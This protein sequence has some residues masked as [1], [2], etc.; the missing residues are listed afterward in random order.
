MNLDATQNV[1]HDLT[2]YINAKR[3]LRCCTSIGLSQKRANKE[4]KRPV[5]VSIAVLE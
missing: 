3:D 4:Q 5:P 1:P 2:L